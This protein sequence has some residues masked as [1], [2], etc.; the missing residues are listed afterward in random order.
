MARWELRLE[1]DVDYRSD[2]R[3]G[4]GVAGG[5][6]VFAAGVLDRRRSELA[7]EYDAWQR[8]GAQ[9]R[10]T[11]GD[12]ATTIAGAVEDLRALYVHV[13]GQ[14]VLSAGIPWQR[15]RRQSGR[16]EQ[17]A[18]TTRQAVSPPLPA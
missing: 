10:T 2:L 18:L 5:R 9:W 14:P 7:D 4:S 11:H 16:S 15:P 3:I 13:E 6:W 17:S 1:P 8:D 12:F